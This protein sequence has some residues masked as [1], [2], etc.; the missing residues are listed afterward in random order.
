M[1]WERAL[2]V[3]THVGKMQRLLEQAITYA[4]ERKASG[5]PIGQFQAVA[6]RIADMKVRIE[7]ARLLT[8]Q[9]ASKLDRDR[10]VSL[11]ASIA[12]LFAS[13]AF[14][15]TALDTIRTLG[16]YGFMADPA[17][18]H[19][20]LAGLANGRLTPYS[21]RSYRAAHSA[22]CE[23]QRPLPDLPFAHAIPLTPI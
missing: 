13:E 5:R 22:P 4:R 10:K 21:S 8:Y 2:L 16:G 15:E 23:R 12:K 7:A 14:V 9:A 17:Q 6:H 11:D 3:A 19:R 1:D 20:P 18:H